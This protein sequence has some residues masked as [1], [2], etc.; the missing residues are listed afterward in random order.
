MNKKVPNEFKEF[1]FQKD[2]EWRSGHFVSRGTGGAGLNL[3][4][5][6]SA[7]TSKIEHRRSCF[8]AH[9]EQCISTIATISVSSPPTSV[10]VDIRD[11]LHG[12]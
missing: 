1:R 6:E 3:E 8:G 9:L 2:D 12:I 11:E 4:I 7:S 5:T 10:S